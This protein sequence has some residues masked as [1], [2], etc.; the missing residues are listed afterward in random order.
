MTVLST[1]LG[2]L[3]LALASGA[4]AESRIAIGV[5]VIGGLLLSTIVTL[6]LTPV[7]YHLLAGFTRPV[8]AIQQ[9]LTAQLGF[10]TPSMRGED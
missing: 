2:A 5:V 4:G 6:F 1:V 8:N 9:R 10:A 3:P 7:L